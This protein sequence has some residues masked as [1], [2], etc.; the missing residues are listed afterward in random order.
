MI[1]FAIT[2]RGSREYVRLLM[3]NDVP[4]DRETAFFY[5]GLHCRWVGVIVDNCA[6]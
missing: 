3:V 2:L 1:L 5:K 4:V 6:S